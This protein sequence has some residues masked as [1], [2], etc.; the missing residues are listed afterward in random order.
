[1]RHAGAQPAAD[2]Q[3]RLNKAIAAAGVASRRGADD[4]I[5]EGKVKVNG[6]VVTEPGTQVDLHKDKVLLGAR[7][8]C[9]GAVRPG[10]C[11]SGHGGGRAP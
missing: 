7:E 11:C 9:V 5:F 8:L 1:M 6:A 2:A 3:L 4:L 10:S